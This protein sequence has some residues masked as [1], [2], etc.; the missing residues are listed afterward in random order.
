MIDISTFDYELPEAQIAQE[1]LPGRSTSRLMVV[2]RASGELTETRFDRVVDWMRPGDVLVR[3]D[4]R[5]MPARVHGTR[6]PDGAEFEA[7]LF[8]ELAPGTWKALCKPGKKL[9]HGTRVKVGALEALVLPIPPDALAVALPGERWLAFGASADVGGT[10]RAHGEMPLPPYVKT[11]HG[12]PE[13]YQ[14]TY[15]KRDGAI[16]APTAG[17]HFTPETFAAVEAKGVEVVDVTLHVGPGTFQ[18]VRSADYTQHRMLPERF[19]IGEGAS[20]A[21]ARARDEGRRVIAVGSTSLRVLETLARDGRLGRA[22]EG[23]TDLYC[24]PG[25]EFQVV[26]AMITNL[27]LPR[28]TLLLLVM[29]FGGVELMRRAYVRAVSGGFRFYSFGDAMF[30][31]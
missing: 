7:T 21:V 22:A 31:V 14:T 26:G 15:A 2:D 20:A 17:F 10:L 25:Y 11:F 6:I 19:E 23:A 8:E 30:I 3:N 28:T 9:K 29:A 27:H 13:R 1:P 4:T 24:Y 18:P 16:A 12:D 5:V